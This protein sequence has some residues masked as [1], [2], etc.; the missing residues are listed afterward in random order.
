MYVLTNEEMREAD[1]YTIESGT[2]AIELME[3]AGLALADEA[4]QMAPTGAIV[5]VCGGGN[6]GGDGFVCARI[7]RERRREVDVVFFAERATKECLFNKEKWE[8]MDGEV[9]SFLPK[10]K[11]YALAVDCLVGTGLRGG[12]QGKNA[13]TVERMNALKGQGVKI[14]SADIPSGL[15]AGEKEPCAVRADVTLCI[16]E[17]KADAVYGDGLDFSGRV[18]RADIGIL[19]PEREYAVLA[20]AK[21]MAGLLPLRKRNSHKGS[22]HRAAIVAGSI[23]YTG[24]AYLSAAAC[25]RSGVGYT[26]LFLP[27]GILSS[28]ILKVPEV[29]LKSTND[30]DRY[31]FNEETMQETLGYESIAYG[32]GMGVSKEVAK[33]AIYLLQRYTGRLVLDA[34]GLNSLAAYEKERFDSLFKNKK[35]DVVL[36]PHL[37]EFSRLSGK[38]VEEIVQEGMFAARE[39]AARYRVNVVLKSAAVSVTDGRKT[40][41]V[42]NGTSGQ[43][44]G[45]SGD[46]LSGVIAGLC[47]NTSAFFGAVLGTYLSQSAAEIAVEE[48][49]EY[50]LTASDCIDCLGAAFLKLTRS[51]KFE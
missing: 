35:C 40:Y 26:A 41:L 23:E 5:C 14:L 11:K 3:R 34:D 17:I 12:L 19:L 46:V 6:N 44:K 30:G 49:G 21:E 25:L 9:V 8:R 18:K 4:E 15:C 42:T 50:S 39:F 24:A 27:K 22:Y 48:S 51:R 32:M 33:G 2:S 31:A 28:Y 38:S 10:N 13:E 1:R 20:E 43:A 16:G 37:K 36:T 47:A 7:L 29:L 45:G